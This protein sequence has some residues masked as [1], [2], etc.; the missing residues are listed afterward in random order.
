MVDEES[1]QHQQHVDHVRAE[2]SSVSARAEASDEKSGVLKH[3]KTT[4]ELRAGD[5]LLDIYFTDIP[6]KSANNV[7]K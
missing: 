3:L 2:F 4:L 6:I 1:V 5:S 7:L